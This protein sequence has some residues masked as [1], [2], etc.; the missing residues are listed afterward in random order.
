MKVTIFILV[1]F[2]A[3]MTRLEGQELTVMFYN[4]E[5]LFDTADDTLKDDDEFLPGGSRH[6]TLNRY[7]QKLNSIARVIIAAG[8]WDPP[9]FVG[10]CEVENENVVKDLVR[11]PVLEGAGYGCVHMESPDPRGIDLALLYRRDIIRIS[12]ARSWIPP[13]D[14]GEVFDSRNLLYVKTSIGSDTVHLILCH[15]P[16]RRGG[17]LAAQDLRDKMAELVRNKADSLQAS[18]GDTASIIIMGDLNAT[19]SDAIISRLTE[20]NRIKNLSAEH[21]DN[22]EGSYRY[23]GVW[24]IIDQIFV[25]SSMTDTIG[26]LYADPLSFRVFS[27]PFLLVDDPDYPGRKPFAT[28]TG[29]RW[30]GGYSDHL[31]VLITISLR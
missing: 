9:A 7:R 26:H 30:T 14:P 29:Y 2:L 28:Y 27:A 8:E 5:N 11:S 12:D 3:V 1:I 24:E 18:S 31:P 20:G 23:Q 22:G 6:W 17:A 21:T 19:S 16:S 15:W 10:L 25:T 4:T 13:T